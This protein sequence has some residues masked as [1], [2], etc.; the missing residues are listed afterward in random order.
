MGTA[1]FLTVAL[2]LL[3]DIVAVALC[4]CVAIFC[5][6]VLLLLILLFWLV[7]FIVVVDAVV[8]PF[9]IQGVTS[10][11]CQYLQQWRCSVNGNYTML[12]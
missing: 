2:A 4:F 7:V 3:A 6:I 12:T 10:W 1:E 11:L 8:Q 9:I 5:V